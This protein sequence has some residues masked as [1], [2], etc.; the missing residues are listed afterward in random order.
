[1]GVCHKDNPLVFEIEGI[2]VYAGGRNRGGGWHVMNPMPDLALGPIGVINS[3]K[4][5]DVLPLGWG[6]TD[7][8]EQGPT[9]TVLE[10]DWPDM[11]IPSNL[12]KEFWKALVIDIKV[13][14]IKSISCQCVGGHGRTGVQVAILAHLLIDKKYREWKTAEELILWVRKNYC[15]K[16][17]ESVVQQ[18]Y[19]A[20]V[21][22]IPEGESTIVITTT[23]WGIEFDES[24]LFTEDEIIAQEADER[25]VFKLDKG[26]EGRKREKIQG[27]EWKR[28]KQTNFVEEDACYESPLVDNYSLTKCEDCDNYEWRSA[29]EEWMLYPCMGCHS[30]NVHPADN[31]LLKGGEGQVECFETREMWHKIEMYDVHNHISF[32]AEAKSR[33]MKIREGK[34]GAS[35]IKAGPRYHP[36][37]FLIRVGNEI[38]PA[39]ELHKEKKNILMETRRLDREAEKHARSKL[40][41]HTDVN[42]TDEITLNQNTKYD[43]W[44]RKKRATNEE[45]E[46]ED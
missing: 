27:M 28:E 11:G 12:G 14:G 39:W 7:T 31:E 34:R 29:S 24:A 18:T 26:K 38:L 45:I 33:H 13:K 30:M 43:K 4:K 8:L 35:E 36:T 46:P 40:E 44:M 15:E 17:V 32:L 21:C 41:K 23:P 19:I 20:E 10:I 16:A 25:R 6:I 22:D 37:F 5:R 9:P 1:M 3:A 2:K 42:A